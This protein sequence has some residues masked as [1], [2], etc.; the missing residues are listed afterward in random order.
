[1][2]YL[3]FILCTALLLL[4]AFNVKESFIAS[5]FVQ[6]D[7]GNA[8]AGASVSVKGSRKH[9]ST[10]YNGAFSIEVP[11]EGTILV[12]SYVGYEPTEVKALK[13]SVIRISL[14]ASARH[15]EEVVVS[16]YAPRSKKE[17]TGASVKIRGYSS[18]QASSPNLQGRAAGVYVSPGKN[19]GM[20]VAGLPN[21]DAGLY[22]SRAPTPEQLAL[23]ERE[24]YDYIQE[25]RF[26]KVSENPLSTFSIDVDA[27][28][29]SNLRRFIQLGQLPPKGSIRIEEMVNYFKY[30]YSQPITEDPFAVHTELADCPWNPRHRL[31]MIGIQGKT[32]PVQNLPPSNLVFLVDV[33]GS[34]Q[35]PQKL[36]LVKASMKMLADQLR[37]QDH[38]SMVVYA[39][40]AGLV[41]P[42]TPG[43]EKKRIKAAI[44]ALEAGG[45]TAG[46]AGIRLAYKTARE[47]FREGGNNRVILCTDGDFNVGAS[48]DD[49]MERLI[50][51][52]RQSGVFLTVLGYGMGNYQ[53]AKMQKLADKGNGNHAYIDN[54]NEARKV[55]VNEFGGTLFTIAK[56]VKLQIEF[57]PALVQGYRLIGYENRILAKEDFNNDRKDAGDLGSGHT[58]TA[59]YEIIPAGVRS[60][61]LD[62][63]DMLRY[64]P[65]IKTSPKSMFGDELMTIKLRYKKPEGMVSKLMVHPVRD[66]RQAWSN[67][68]ENF[69]FAASVAG[70]GMLLR[71]S[72]FKGNLEYAAVRSMAASSIGRDTEGYRHE[73]LQLV[74]MAAMLAD[75]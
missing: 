62:S 7:A 75:K 20:R 74:D 10:D 23:F 12:V 51:E 58:V 52:E 56:D 31:A 1:M 66:R 46:G 34:M 6:D 61:D 18:M 44:D 8:L 5:G 72:A 9:V 15:L 16:G 68:S 39:G 59:F 24:G 3:S 48:S 70:F 37:E 14:S 13:N 22:G 36:P 30:N 38:V 27:A 55:L 21:R 67:C 50:E 42:P 28:S 53:D 33:S 32:I 29:Y 43:T 40:A 45:S 26:L 41:L 25:N 57:N 73:F 65:V 64:Q 2:R 47:H 60:S 35:D 69:R 63:V 54:L 17:F 71:N 19:P 4:L 11:G 49:A